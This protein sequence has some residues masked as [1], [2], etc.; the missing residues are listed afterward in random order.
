M[1]TIRIRAKD[2]MPVVLLTLLSIV[3]ALA[4]ELLWD[5]VSSE[6]YLYESAWYAL[7]GWMQVS[8]S[9][10]GILLIWLLYSSSVMRFRWVPATVDSVF[11]FLIGIIEFTLIALLGPGRIGG[12]FLVL[13][14]IF[15]VMTWVSH[16]SYRKSE[17]R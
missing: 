9:F 4:L 7:I 16:V 10:M 15:A 5:Y 6:D 3:Q 2:Q 8:A 1:N 17:T 14:L 12:W 13:A 11:P